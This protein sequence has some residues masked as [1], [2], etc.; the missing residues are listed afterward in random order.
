[1]FRILALAACVLGTLTTHAQDAY[2]APGKPRYL[3]NGRVS[4]ESRT[5]RRPNEI[6]M[7]LVETTPE[8]DARFRTYRTLNGMGNAFGYV[9]GFGLGYGLSALITQG[10]GSRQRGGSALLLSGLGAMGLGLL[11]NGQ[12]N[13]SLKQ[14]IDLYDQQP[15]P[16]ISFV[17][18]LEWQ[19]GRATLGIVVRF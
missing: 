14:A 18:R 2:A 12:A 11:L 19:P 10:F 4:Y 5:L 16:T 17:P 3:G 8:V 9:G 1:M 15:T 13:R 6:Q 7:A